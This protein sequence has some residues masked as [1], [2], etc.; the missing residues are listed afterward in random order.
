MSVCVSRLI[1]A[2]VS[3]KRFTL[4]ELTLLNDFQRQYIMV[5]LINYHPVKHFTGETFS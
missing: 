5:K 2:D 3:E 1:W 4:E